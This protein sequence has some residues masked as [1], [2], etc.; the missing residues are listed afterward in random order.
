[1]DLPASTSRRFNSASPYKLNPRTHILHDYHDYDFL[2]H[3]VQ[4]QADRTQLLDESETGER[5]TYLLSVS[6]KA[7]TYSKI[8]PGVAAILSLFR[9][10]R[11]CTEVA[12]LVAQATGMPMLEA[13]FFRDLAKT[14]IIIPDAMPDEVEGNSAVS[15]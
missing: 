8:D 13:S 14:E 6:N 5:G 11:R 4:R 2:L 10:P 3:Q 15:R 7:S 1:M 12:D 9:Q